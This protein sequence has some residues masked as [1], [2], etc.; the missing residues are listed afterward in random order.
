MG[1]RPPFRWNCGLEFYAKC[2]VTD[3]Y[4]MIANSIR[5]PTINAITL[6]YTFIV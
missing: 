3:G 6:V 4:A 2:Y 1:C 5:L